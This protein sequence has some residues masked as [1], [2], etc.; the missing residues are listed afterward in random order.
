[1]ID[2][3][4]VERM[5]EVGRGAFGV[6]WRATWRDMEVAVKDVHDADGLQV[7]PRRC[8]AKYAAHLVVD[9]RI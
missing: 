7:H 2:P 4:E 8:L 5:E 6:V 3:S 9:I 1:M